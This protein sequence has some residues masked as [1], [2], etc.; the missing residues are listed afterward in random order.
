[1]N[2]KHTKH[3]VCAIAIATSGAA[4]SQTYP[5]RPVRLVVGYPP[6]G[7]VDFVAR[8]LQHSFGEA[9]GQ[10]IVIENKGG[11]GG[12]IAAEDVFRSKPDGY[13]LLLIY[14]RHAI[15]NI[16][17]KNVRFNALESFDYLSLIG[18]SPLVVIA[19]KTSGVD[20]MDKYVSL[21]QANP[22]KVNFATSGPGVAET[23]KGEVIQNALGTRVT[24][25]PFQGSGAA[26]NALVAGQV[27]VTL[28][29]LSVALSM[30]RG[31][32][33]VP[34]AVG[35][36]S[37]QQLIPQVPP[38]SNFFKDV[39]LTAWVGLVGPKGMPAEVKTRIST[40]LDRALNDPAVRKNL[41]SSG[42]VVQAL[43]PDQALAKAKGDHDAT[44][45]LMR[46]RNIKAE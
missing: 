2:L 30:I 14:E 6:G 12:N 32:K 8:A 26:L 46:T 28:T 25:I 23:L 17:Y 29:S 19:S 5:D 34:L 38:I 27:D 20:S 7:P 15:A 35:T 16:F 22:G 42:F 21:A 10:P 41:E 1:M 37:P 39:D 4:L 24:Y 11:A 3:L 13:S 18:Y 45:S 40:A 44:L 31:D 43:G 36:Q 33:V 9:L